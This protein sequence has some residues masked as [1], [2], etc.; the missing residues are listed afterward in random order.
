MDGQDVPTLGAF[1]A[2]TNA[3]RD[4]RTAIENPGRG[5]SDPIPLPIPAEAALAY[6]RDQLAGRAGIYAAVE[7][8]ATSSSNA[9][10]SRSESWAPAA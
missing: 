2:A 9:S 10:A 1:K 7:P 3:A 8:S 5:Q 4:A 6:R